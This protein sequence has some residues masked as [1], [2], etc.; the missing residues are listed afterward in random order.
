[1]QQPTGFRLAAAP[2]R[3]ALSQILLRMVRRNRR[4]IIGGSLL[5]LLATAALLA[6]VLAPFDPFTPLPDES[7][8]P[9]NSRHW[10][11]TDI[12]GRDVFSRIL[13]GARISLS[14]GA[15]AIGFGMAAGVI[16]GVLSGFRGGF[17]DMT[18][19]RVVDLMLA[20]PGILL[21]LGIVAV[22]G[23]GLSNVMI[24]VGVGNIPRF[25]RLVRASTLVI[26]E[27]SYLEAAVALGG[28]S[29]W[30]MRRHILPNILS[31]AIVL[32]TMNFGN[33]ILAAAALSFLGLGAQAP[34][35]EWGLMLSSS[36]DYL[37]Q[38][39]WWSTFPGIAIMVAVLAINMIG[40]GLRDL[41][42]PR[43]RHRG[44]YENA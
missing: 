37:R 15:L 36:R 13:F 17:F 28:S 31:P 29:W 26:K 1:M 14:V 4:S 18:I 12:L 44:G 11:G 25:T 8:S 16:L 40:D 9:P 24:A 5:G 3:A 33:A 2:S 41:L 42:D 39:W 21:A 20:F 38:A 6:S 32:A 34:S 35:P 22:L 10:L 19:M 27:Q 7:L 43:L 23:P 30:I